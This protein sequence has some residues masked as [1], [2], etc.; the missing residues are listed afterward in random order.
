[1]LPELRDPF[2][3]ERID[4]PVQL[5]WGDHD[6]MVFRS[7]ADRVLD[8]VPDSELAVIEDCGHCPQIEA[9][10]QLA[11]LLLDFPVAFAQTA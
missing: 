7:G 2:D 8:A 11:E 4:C 3:L 1:M 9:A 6:V 5:V 10:D